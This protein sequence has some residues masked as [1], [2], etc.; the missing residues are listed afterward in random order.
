MKVKEPLV[1]IIIRT[2]NE[3]RWLIMFDK[4]TDQS[5]KNFEII[6]DNSSTDNTFKL[7]IIK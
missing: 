4:I 2:K 5:Y 3:E 7:K 6:V 1:S